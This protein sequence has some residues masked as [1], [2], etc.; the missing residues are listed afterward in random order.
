M[1]G[2]NQKAVNQILQEEGILEEG[3]FGVSVM[4]AFGYRVKDPRPKTWQELDEVVKWVK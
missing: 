2:F 4:A 1:E 3:R